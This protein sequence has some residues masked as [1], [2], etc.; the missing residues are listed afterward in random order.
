MHNECLGTFKRFGKDEISIN[1]TGMDHILKRHS[2]EVP[3]GSDGK[4]T[5]FPN[6]T[7]NEQIIKA[8][9]AVYSKGNRKSPINQPTQV[10]EKRIRLNGETA[11]YRLIINSNSQV[12][13][14]FKI[15]EY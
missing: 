4:G 1:T 2:P 9:G 10:F 7:T 13:S 5:L 8:I 11:N 14:F 15:G 12:T 6:N 3:P